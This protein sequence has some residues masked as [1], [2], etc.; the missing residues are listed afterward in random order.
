MLTTADA[1]GISLTDVDCVV[2]SYR[3]NES[4]RRYFKERNPAIE[5]IVPEHHFAHACQ[6]FLPSPFE[7]AAVMVVD[8]QGVPLARAGGD[9]LSGCLAYG[10][11]N[12][13]ELLRDLPARHSLGSMYSAFTRAVGFET[14]EEGNTMG[15]AP[16]GKPEVYDIL[17]QG[18][19]YNSL[20]FDIRNPKK[21]LKR[22]L[23]RKSFI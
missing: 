3:Y 4:A 20:D 16:Y 17:K 14:N 12:S 21:M 9:Q 23:F 10:T 22:G 1:E 7:E 2:Y 13:I 8:G 5:F 19:K 11:G 18:L 15:L 6:A